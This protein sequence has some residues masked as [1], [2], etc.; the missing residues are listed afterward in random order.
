MDVEN[1]LTSGDE[2]QLLDVWTAPSERRLRERTLDRV[3]AEGDERATRRIE[4]HLAELPDVTPLDALRANHALVG[5]LAG[6]RWIEIR[7]AREQ[8]NTWEQIGAAL[9]MSRQGA[10]DWYRRKIAD[11]EQYDVPGHDAERARAVLDDTS[12]KG[13]AR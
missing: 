8:G 10:Q 3:R 2:Q 7:A 4:E 12:E 1:A 6:R 5:L 13:T 9:G 11:Q